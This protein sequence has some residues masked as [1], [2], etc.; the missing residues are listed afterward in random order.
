MCVSSQA[1]A[2]PS[3]PET[4]I[5]VKSGLS[6]VASESGENLCPLAGNLTAPTAVLQTD[7]V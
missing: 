4:A 3:R 7:T 6:K 2:K 1:R 5:L